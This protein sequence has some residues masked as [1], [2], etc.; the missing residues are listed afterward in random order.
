MIRNDSNNF[1]L[2]G[3]IPQN[4]AHDAVYRPFCRGIPPS[5]EKLLQSFLKALLHLSA[6]ALKTLTLL[7][8]SEVLMTEHWYLACKILVTSPFNCLYAVILTFDLVQGQICCCP[9]GGGGGG[10]TIL[11]IFMLKAVLKVPESRVIFIPWWL[12]LWCCIWIV[13]HIS[14]LN[15]LPCQQQAMSNY[16]GILKV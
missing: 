14:C 8:S 2:D 9:G 11:L 7:I 3:G 5:T 13:K 6:C 4:Y 16:V 12:S 15:S 10:G 1:S